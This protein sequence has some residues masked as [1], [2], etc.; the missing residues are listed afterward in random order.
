MSRRALIF[1]WLL[2]TALGLVVIGFAMFV[3]PSKA[4]SEIVR[5]EETPVPVERCKSNMIP[6]DI[7]ELGVLAKKYPDRIIQYRILNEIET[8]AFNDYSVEN[9]ILP[10]EGW[11]PTTAVV[12]IL[13]GDA[14]ALGYGYDENGCYWGSTKFLL[15]P[16]LDAIMKAVGVKDF[17]SLG[18]RKAS[19]TAGS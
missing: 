10:A 12:I 17:D 19:P 1:G 11:K 6:E 18:F 5:V 9:N 4:R 15:P 14:Y 7:A 13:D 2:A 3:A 8:A 16:F